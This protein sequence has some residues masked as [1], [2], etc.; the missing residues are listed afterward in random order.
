MEYLGCSQSLTG[1]ELI[2]LK[3]QSDDG[4]RILQATIGENA[5]TQRQARPAQGGPA[6][7]GGGQAKQSRRDGIHLHPCQQEAVEETW[8]AWQQGHHST[9]VSLPTGTGKTEV[10]LDLMHRI[11][12]HVLVIQVCATCGV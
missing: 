12:D 9:L 11:L 1:M 7:E 3:R 4:I 10:V 8:L 5:L 6:A 2:L